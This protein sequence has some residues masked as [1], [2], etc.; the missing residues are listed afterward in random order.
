MND[1]A[2]VCTTTSVQIDDCWNNIG[3]WGKQ[4]PRCPKLEKYIHC[5][6]CDIF[7]NAGKQLLDREIPE[8]YLED[9]TIAYA[10]E[11]PS[12]TKDK[13]IAVL[14]FRLGD[15]WI[16]IPTQYVK[17][18]TK[19]GPIHK[20]PH[21]DPRTVRGLVNVRG[22]LKICLSIGSLLHLTPTLTYTNDSR[23]GTYARMVVVAHEHWEF[24][25]PVSE[26]DGINYYFEK[27]LENVPTTVNKAKATFTSGIINM[28]ERHIA[29]LDAPLL[30]YALEKCLK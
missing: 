15:E 12:N 30:I 7:S 1:H 10:R 23:K 22:E 25:F 14:I 26:V 4:T 27:D 13:P 29:C 8:H 6:N 11:K 2:A 9:W 20:V 24:V 28:G 3:V 19:I 18:I 5:R 17:E 16:S 21:K